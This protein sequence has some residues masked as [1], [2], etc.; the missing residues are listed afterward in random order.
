M[1]N[2]DGIISWNMDGIRKCIYMFISPSKK[3]YVGKTVHLRQRFSKHAR[4]NGQCRAIH[5]A[6]R[7]YG[8]SNFLKVILEVF[9]DDVSDELMSEREMYWIKY[10]ESF[11][12]KGY[13]LT[14]GGEGCSGMKHSVATR[15]KLAEINRGRNVTQ[16][17][18]EK[19]RKINLGKKMSPDACKKMSVNHVSHKH[20]AE[21]K[22]KISNT[23]KNTLNN[24]KFGRAVCGVDKKG[25]RNVFS[26]CSHAER[27]LSQATGLKF[28]NSCISKCANKRRKSHHGWTFEFVTQEIQF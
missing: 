26:S 17:T 1:S 18:R 24:T 22:R 5:S 7:K 21:T 20:S 13:N 16:G 6:I 8:W 2:A 15:A 10:H 27:V 25:T 3:V 19:L 28:D 14:T 23:L 12:P 9:N 11:G 4:A